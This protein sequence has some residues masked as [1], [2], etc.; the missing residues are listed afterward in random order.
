MSIQRVD[1][2]RKANTDRSHVNTEKS[3]DK[4]YSY[5]SWHENTK[6]AARLYY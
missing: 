4:T 1:T 5:I 2:Y 6:L 3:T